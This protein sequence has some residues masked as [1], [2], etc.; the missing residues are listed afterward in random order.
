MGGHS[1]LATG[2]LFLPAAAGTILGANTASRAVGHIGG[3]PVASTGLALAA[4]GA[5]VPAIW[6]GTA[7][8][9]TGIAIGA[10]GLGATLVAAT[11]TAL[12]R[13]AHH[14]AGITSGVVNT[15]HE[16][17]AA[18]GVA[19]I[20]SIAAA[21]LTTHTTADADGFT[22]GFASAAPARTARRARGGATGT[23]RQTT[24][25]HGR[26]HALTQPSGGRRPPG[27][28]HASRMVWMGRGSVRW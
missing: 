8:L 11:T 16:L 25:R 19:A 27:P 21:G 13:V 24:P 15:F 9:A 18:L 23:R 28:P 6:L 10:A 7:G 2:L 26:P 1:A 14:D 17:G 3:R 20:S 12:A 4:G 5:A 22:R